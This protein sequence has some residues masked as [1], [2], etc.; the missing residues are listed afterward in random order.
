MLIQ[1]NFAIQLCNITSTCRCKVF[2]YVIIHFLRIGPSFTA[3][4][5]CAILWFIIIFNR[6]LPYLPKAKEILLF[7]HQYTFLPG[8]LKSLLLL[9][10]VLLQLRLFFSILCIF[11]VSVTSE[12]LQL[13]F[14]VIENRG[15]LCDTKSQNTVFYYSLIL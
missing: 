4:N 7:R 10:S 13:I 2:S 12:Q 11:K 8:L 14:A 5:G 15:V 1:P 3:C 6:Y 9:R